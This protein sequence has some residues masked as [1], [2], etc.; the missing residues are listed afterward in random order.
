MLRKS[1][2]PDPYLDPDSGVFWIRI[3]IEIFGWIRVQ[4]I[5]IQN[6]AKHYSYKCGVPPPSF[7]GS[8]SDAA[9]KGEGEGGGSNQL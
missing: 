4:Q 1:F 9:E 3:R 6:T 8:G 5:R 7:D 2:D